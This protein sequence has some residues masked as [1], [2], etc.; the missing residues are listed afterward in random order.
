MAKN[1]AKPRTSKE[2]APVAVAEKARPAGKP[3]KKKKK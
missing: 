1:P 3:A 2:V